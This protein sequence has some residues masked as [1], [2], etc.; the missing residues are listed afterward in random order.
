MR[1]HQAATGQTGELAPPYSMAVRIDPEG[2]ET[3]AL[4]DR[5]DL[6]GADVLEVGCGDGRLAWRYADR[7]A[8]VTAIEPFADSIARAKESPREEHLPIEF[9]NVAFEDPAAESDP[10]G[11]L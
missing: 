5:V 9:R 10:D 7:V 4:F 3:A 1:F 11:M 8:R 2:N 6:R